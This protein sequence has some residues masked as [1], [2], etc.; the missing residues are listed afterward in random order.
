MET[1]HPKSQI[2]YFEHPVLVRMISRVLRDTRIPY[3]DWY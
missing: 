3:N 2:E 1:N